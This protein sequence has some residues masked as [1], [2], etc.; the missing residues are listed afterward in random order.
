M[1]LEADLSLQEFTKFSLDN[2]IISS[3]YNDRIG[4]Q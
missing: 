4:I 1:L 2:I 3:D